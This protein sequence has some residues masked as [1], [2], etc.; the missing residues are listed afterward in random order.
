MMHNFPAAAMRLHFLIE[1]RSNSVK[2]EEHTVSKR[3]HPPACLLPVQHL[4]SS[5]VNREVRRTF[6]SIKRSWGPVELVPVVDRAKHVC[7]LSMLGIGENGVGLAWHNP[8]VKSPSLTPS[9]TLRRMSECLCT[10]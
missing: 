9:S 3:S 8:S 2:H 6:R 10:A 4:S 5:A 1:T 7:D